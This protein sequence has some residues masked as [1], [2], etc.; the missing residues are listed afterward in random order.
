MNALTA[1]RSIRGTTSYQRNS[2]VRARGGWPNNS[3]TEA[4][5]EL[6]DAL[7]IL[8]MDAAGHEQAI[9]PESVCAGEIR[10]HGIPD[11]QNPRKRRRMAAALGCEF[12]GALVDRPVRL[13][14]EDH[15][16]AEFAIESAT[17][18]AQ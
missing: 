18:P 10:P 11:R 9:D 7:K 12:Y 15:L 3:L 2:R 13:A 6:V 16:A 1:L 17:A 14:V 8:G 4:G 5:V